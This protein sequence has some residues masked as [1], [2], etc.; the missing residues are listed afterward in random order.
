MSTGP[1][2][3]SPITALAQD[4]T[5]TYTAINNAVKVFKRGREKHSFH[6]AK[7]AVIVRILLLG[8]KM[9]TVDERNCLTVWDKQG[10]Y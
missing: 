4:R 10:W 8:Q 6:T 9:V 2:Q 3:S 1:Q 7:D 5:T